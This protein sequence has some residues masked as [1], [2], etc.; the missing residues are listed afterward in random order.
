VTESA[1]DPPGTKLG[2]GTHPAAQQASVHQVPLCSQLPVPPSPMVEAWHPARPFQINNNN[3]T[4][5]VLPLSSPPVGSSQASNRRRV[6]WKLALQQHV[7][8]KKLMI[9]QCNNQN[10][11]CCCCNIQSTF[12]SS[13]APCLTQMHKWPSLQQ[14]LWNHTY[15][16][17]CLLNLPNL[18]HIF[19]RQYFLQILPPWRISI[20][21]NIA[22]NCTTFSSRCKHVK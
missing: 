17:S 22:S 13:I 8:R 15:H 5:A 19:S 6:A 20:W 14:C 3:T 4:I 21:K 10:C 18:P 7:E 1:E 2:D 16:P 9:N 12:A 11:C